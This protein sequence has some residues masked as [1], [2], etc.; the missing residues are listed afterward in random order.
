MKNIAKIIMIVLLIQG[1]KGQEEKTMNTKEDKYA[2]LN[3]KIAFCYKKPTNEQFRKKI[4][5]IFNT[6]ISTK[7]ETEIRLS[8]DK[9]P[10]TVLINYNF[11][12]PFNLHPMIPDEES[13]QKMDKEAIEKAYDYIIKN[14]CN[15]NKM[16]F[17]NDIHATNWIKK[18][19]LSLINLAQEYGYTKNK[20]WLQFAFSKSKLHEPTVLESF[21]FGFRCD[22]IVK[23]DGG[24]E[25][26][27]QWQLRKDMLD[28][29]IEYRAELSQLSTVANMVSNGKPQ[30]YEEDTEELYAYLMAHCYKAGQSGIIEYLYDTDPKMIEVFRKKDFYGIEDLE[31]FTDNFYIP[32]NKR[33]GLSSLGPDPYIAYGV[34]NDP[35]G[36]TNLRDGK[37]TSAKVIKK[38]K[39]GEKFGI[40]TNTGEWWIVVTEDGTRGRIHSS[41]ITIIKE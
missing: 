10:E 9:Y 41:R 21:L 31:D 29:M 25:C 16:I 30:M 38:I 8:T 36:Y 37:G 20:D 40:E 3:E 12:I 32:Q 6:D 34:I 28:K 17:N 24:Y 19:S 18:N 15:Y 1:C 7:N 35:D 26:K 5:E 11:I 2:M 27:G 14:T 23:N 33:F 22:S 4:L 39:E 13:L